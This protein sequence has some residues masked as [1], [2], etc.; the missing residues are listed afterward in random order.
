VKDPWDLPASPDPGW[1]G[2]WADLSFLN[3][4]EVDDELAE[5]VALIIAEAS[6]LIPPYGSPERAAYGQ[7]H[8]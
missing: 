1:D 4:T 2:Q 8:S 6:A 3:E 5:A 7:L